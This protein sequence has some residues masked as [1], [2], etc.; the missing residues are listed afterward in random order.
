MNHRFCPHCG[1]DL[2]K[3]QPIIINDFSML[4]PQS[5]LYYRGTALNLTMTGRNLCWTLMK[6]YPKPVRA[7]VLLDRMDSI[8]TGNVIAVYLT[9]IRKELRKIGAPIPFHH[10]RGYGVAWNV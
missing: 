10:V 9:R 8:G 5:P 6:N 2:V 3:D 1:Y 7:D 4:G